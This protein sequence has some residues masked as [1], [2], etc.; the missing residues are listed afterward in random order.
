MFNAFNRWLE[1]LPAPFVT[2]SGKFPAYK[3]KFST[4][5]E[6]YS[7][8]DVTIEKGKWQ[9]VPTGLHLNETFE[10]C[11]DIHVRPI[12]SLAAMHGVT[13]MNSPDTIDPNY[14]GEIKVTLIN[15]S[16]TEDY[17]IKKGDAIALL[18]IRSGVVKIREFKVIEEETEKEEKRTGYTGVY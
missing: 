12:A 7:A 17:H 15:H 13:V 4:G 1:R 6:L 3:T 9:V 14:C 5:A 10:D 18:V 2:T 11:C 16:Q 8:K